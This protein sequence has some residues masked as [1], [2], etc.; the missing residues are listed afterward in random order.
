MVFLYLFFP[1]TTIILFQVAIKLEKRNWEMVFYF[2]FAFNRR[3][4]ISKTKADN[5][6]NGDLQDYPVRVK[7]NLFVGFGTIQIYFFYYKCS[8]G[9]LKKMLKKNMKE[10]L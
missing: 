8:F 10:S 7:L 6:E 2:Y 1:H 3:R 5:Q 4:F 9:N